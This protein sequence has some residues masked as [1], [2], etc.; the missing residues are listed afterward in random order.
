MHFCD[1]P[2]ATYILCAELGKY[3]FQSVDGLNEN[4]K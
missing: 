3:L 1:L 2:K 4:E